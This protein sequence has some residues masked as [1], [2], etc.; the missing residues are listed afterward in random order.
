MSAAPAYTVDDLESGLR[1]LNHLMSAI[2][3]IQFQLSPGEA[4]DRVDSL[5][6]IARGIAVEVYRFAEM[7]P[8]ERAAQAGGSA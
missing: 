1:H 8:E 3:E 4:D 7:T 2:C 6:W 5:L